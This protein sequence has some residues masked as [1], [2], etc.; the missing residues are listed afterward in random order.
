ME[1]KINES[2]KE[3][4]DEDFYIIDDD[5]VQSPIRKFKDANY[6]DNFEKWVAERNHAIQF[7]YNHGIG[8]YAKKSDSDKSDDVSRFRAR[9]RYLGQESWYDEDHFFYI[10]LDGLDKPLLSQLRI[11]N[12]RTHHE[13]YQKSHS[14]DKY[15]RVQCDTVLNI[16]ITNKNQAIDR[17]PF[18]PSTLSDRT[19]ISIETTYNEKTKTAQQKKNLD[20]FISQLQNGDYVTNKNGVVLK[21]TQPVITMQWIKDNI[22]P[23]PQIVITRGR[24]T[25]NKINPQYIRPN[26]YLKKGTI[27]NNPTLKMPPFYERPKVNVL[28]KQIDYGDLEETGEIRNIKGVDYEIYNYQGSKIA[29]AKDGNMDTAYPLNSRGNLIKDKIAIYEGRINKII[30]ESINWFIKKYCL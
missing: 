21:D 13:T 18:K 16:I 30:T 29:I 15:G 22:D 6:K 23:N 20:D 5:D 4:N 1:K 14:N 27:D 11:S 9:A 12:H 7:A 8:L 2:I 17:C 28:P 3:L 26:Q 10:K 25:L 19:I 24:E